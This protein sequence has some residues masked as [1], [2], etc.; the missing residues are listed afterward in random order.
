MSD[1]LS[2]AN[3]P[4]ATATDGKVY[5]PAARVFWVDA[6]YANPTAVPTDLIGPWPISIEVQKSLWHHS[7]RFQC[8]FPLFADPAF[9]Y[10]FW[11]Q[12]DRMI[13]GIEVMF[14]QATGQGRT[15]FIPWTR[16]L[17]GYVQTIKGDVTKG[18]VTI[19]G[20]SIEKIFG[21]TKYNDSVTNETVA[22]T[23]GKFCD[24]H[25]FGKDIDDGGEIHGRKWSDD[26]DHSSVG[27]MSRQLTQKDMISSLADRYGYYTWMTAD[28]VLH[29]KKIDTTQRKSW[30]ITCPT[31]D[32]F[33]GAARHKPSNFDRLSFEHHLDI[34]DSNPTV[35]SA[36]V[37]TQTKQGFV[38]RY[39]E[40]ATEEKKK[41]FLMQAEQ[42]SQEDQQ[43]ATKNR[44]LNLIGKEWDMDCTL[45]DPNW[46]YFEMI[47]E[48]NIQGTNSTFDGPYLLDS[49][50]YQLDSRHGWKVHIKGK[51]GR[52]GTVQTNDTTPTGGGLG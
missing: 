29:F 24:E 47:D 33:Q 38:Y 19:K 42:M 7:D 34:A 13:V 31:P 12:K 32:I 3:D 35:V 17:T 6:G 30:Q 11:G 40:G 14:D 9:S 18:I 28:A 10:N 16:I 41:E 49:I 52:P 45:G 1:T 21:D 43:I 4:V 44:F 25:G 5:F 15:N 8:E 37:D 27:Q 51:V 20:C 46:V 2:V 39:P 26:K 36:N 50:V 48:I 23:I 22:E